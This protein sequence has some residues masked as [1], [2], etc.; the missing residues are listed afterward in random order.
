M[1]LDE[2]LLTGE[3]KAILALRALFEGEG[4]RRY[5]MSRFE[6]YDFYARCR[7]FLDDSILTFTDVSGKLMALKP[8]VTLSMLMGAEDGSRLYYNERV[9]RSVDGAFREMTQAG[10]EHIGKVSVRGAAAMAVLAG[11]AL[12][13]VFP[14]SVLMLSHL[15]FLRGAVRAVKMPAHLEEQALNCIRRKNADGVQSLCM[16]AGIGAQ[17]AA[18]LSDMAALCA[19]IEK[20]AALLSPLVQNAQMEKAVRALE[21]V[22]ALALQSPGCAPIMVDLSVMNPMRYYDGLTFTGFAEGLPRA[23]LSGGQ[24]GGLMRRMGR[25]GSGAGF[26]VYLNELEDRP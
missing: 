22:A 1:A 10:A 2:R 3:E 18:L 19:P 17:G 5:R 21:T 8:D 26:A 15:G 14:F 9:Y 7:D 4:Y 20:A 25:R 24:Y 13:T 16:A 12:K 6:P 23:V 11:R